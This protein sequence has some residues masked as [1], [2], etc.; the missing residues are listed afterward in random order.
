MRR[1]RVRH[2]LGLMLMHLLMRP[3]DT[4]YPLIPS[5]P[6]MMV[7]NSPAPGDIFKYRLVIV[8][9]SV[10]PGD[11]PKSRYEKLERRISMI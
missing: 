6:L 9:D 3:L 10:G 7:S 2:A 1:G 4:N 8:I 5:A 11:G